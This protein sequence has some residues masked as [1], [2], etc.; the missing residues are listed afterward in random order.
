MIVAFVTLICHTVWS[1]SPKKETKRKCKT[2]FQHPKNDKRWVVSWFFAVQRMNDD[3]RITQAIAMEACKNLKLHISHLSWLHSL[4]FVEDR[5]RFD[6]VLWE[7]KILY[8]LTSFQCQS[9]FS[10]SKARLNENEIYGDVQIQDHYR[11][12]THPPKKYSFTESGARDYEWKKN[13]KIITLICI[14]LSAKS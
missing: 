10:C 5:K 4:V 8:A 13:E 9:T 6:K 2:F 11:L 7:L 3:V 1:F 14:Q 12:I